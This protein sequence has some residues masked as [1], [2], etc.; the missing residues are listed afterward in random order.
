M[1]FVSY[2]IYYCQFVT[3]LLSIKYI[4]LQLD[5][6]DAGSLYLPPHFCWIYWIYTF[7]PNSTPNC[8]LSYQLLSLNAVT[9]DFHLF[10]L[11]LIITSLIRFI[12]IEINCCTEFYADISIYMYGF[13][14]RFMNTIFGNLYC[15]LSVY[16]R[17]V[18]AVILDSLP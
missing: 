6:I 11:E 9:F 10:S 12:T 2:Q 15:C 7:N 16:A 3:F 4:K 1:Q 14:L 17:L 5:A 13:L 18:C 8:K